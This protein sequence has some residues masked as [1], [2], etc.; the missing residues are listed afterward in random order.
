MISYMISCSARFQMCQWVTQLRLSLSGSLRLGL[1]TDYDDYCHSP[2]AR[3]RD[4]RED[5]ESDSESKQTNRDL[6]LENN[7]DP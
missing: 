5:S 1:G 7:H 4:S 6:K 2:A 3:D